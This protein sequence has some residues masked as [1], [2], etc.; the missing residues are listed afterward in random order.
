MLNR[1]VTFET[2]PGV[3]KF[4]KFGTSNYKH[5][6]VPGTRDP[7][8]WDVFLTME[9]VY[10]MLEPGEKVAF[11]IRHSER[12]QQEVSEDLTPDGRRYALE[13]GGPQLAGGIAGPDDIA[14]YSSEKQRCIDTAT[15]IGQGSGRTLPAPTTIEYISHCPYKITEPSAG[16]EDY[17]LFAYDLP[18]IHGGVFRDKA[19]TTAQILEVV[20]SRMTKTI[21]LFVTHDQ[22]LEIFVVDMCQKQIALRFWPGA[23]N[24]GV[25]E[26]R[27]ITYMAGLAIIEH[28]DGSYEWCP[29]RTLSRGYQREY[30]EKVYPD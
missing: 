17:S 13:I 15:L 21:N 10:Q 2:S 11:V 8:P 30:D 12:Y 26:K 24:D 4:L 28:L 5:V 1:I 27:W 16:W 29:V 3:R 9:E 20:Q 18:S 19:T 25:S 23:V 22:L 6:A 7:L 14:L